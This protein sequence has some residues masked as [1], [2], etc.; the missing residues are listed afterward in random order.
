MKNSPNV[1]FSRADTVP[2]M[3]TS[4]PGP[5]SYSRNDGFGSNSVSVKFPK[6]LRLSSKNEQMPGPV[7]YDAD[8]SK[9]MKSTPKFTIGR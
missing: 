1:A 2:V 8:K 6:E 5:S 7:D 4:T 9:T 3:R